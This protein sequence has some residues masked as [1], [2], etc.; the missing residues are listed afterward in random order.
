MA[1]SIQ[2][3]DGKIKIFNDLDLIAVVLL[4]LKLLSTAPK[5]DLSEKLME[6]WRRTLSL[7]GPGTI[8]LELESLI[9]SNDD[10]AMLLDLLRLVEESLL[11][12]GD[13]VPASILNNLSDAPEGVIFFD[14]KCAFIIDALNSLEELLKK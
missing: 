14:F 5:N 13:F 7:Y 4:L 10:K 9:R 6:S 2:E 3:F 11:D 12:Y 1:H 8:E